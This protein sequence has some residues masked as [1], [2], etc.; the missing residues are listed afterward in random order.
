MSQDYDARTAL[1]ADV[2]IEPDLE[3]AGEPAAGSAQGSEGVGSLLSGVI[4]DLQG[5]LRGEVQLAKTELKEE[6]AAAGG[7]AALAGAGGATGFI[8]VIFVLLAFTEL[9]AK[10]IQRWKAFALV[11]F[12]LTGTAA[13]LGL[14]GK[15]R[16][17][18]ANLVP[19]RTIESLKQDTAW[20]KR[21]VEQVAPIQAAARPATTDDSA[22]SIPPV[23][24]DQASGEPLPG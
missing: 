3:T 11:G 13:G 6:A 2:V 22:Q 16:L 7:A 20:V 19:R 8:G 18:A 15:N 17:T 24:P 9:L 23:S 10:R 12:A 14:A 1:T 5:L 21:Q 4:K